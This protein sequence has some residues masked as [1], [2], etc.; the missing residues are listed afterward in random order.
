MLARQE[1]SEDE[2]DLGYIAS[3]R[4]E[5]AANIDVQQF[6]STKVSSQTVNHFRGASLGN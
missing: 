3:R 6:S 1:S 5:K 4:L 2:S